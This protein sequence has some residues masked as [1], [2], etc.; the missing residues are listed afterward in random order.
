MLVLKNER[1]VLSM[2]ATLSVDQATK[3]LI[4]SFIQLCHHLQIGTLIGVTI[5]LV[6]VCDMDKFHNG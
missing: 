5:I 2:C 6:F 3:T 4:F 1:E